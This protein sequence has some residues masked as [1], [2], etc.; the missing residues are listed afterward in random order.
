MN[1]THEI[2]VKNRKIIKASVSVLFFRLKEKGS[3]IAECPALGLVTEGKNL[4][5]AKNMFEE[6]FSLWHEVV[7]E[8]G[9]IHQV[10]KEL[11][12]KLSK[13]YKA[14]SKVDYSSV[15]VHLLE[16]TTKELPIPVRV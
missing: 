16:V 5:E 6:S 11:G 14:P 9:N 4:T 7:T 10:L 1:N 2:T 12:W 3:V 8:D 15:P 13:T